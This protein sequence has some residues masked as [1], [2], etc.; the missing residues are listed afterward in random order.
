METECL[1]YWSDVFVERGFARYMTLPQFLRDPQGICRQ[2]DEA[3]KEKGFRP[4]LLRQ[5]AAIQRQQRAIS[6]QLSE[7][8]FAAIEELEKTVDGFIRRGG[9][10]F[11]P[12]KHHA[13][14]R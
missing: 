14:P 6:E 7:P 9:R 10:Y 1:E 4:L 11:E 13:H 2:F 3:D 12:I 8:L 5:H